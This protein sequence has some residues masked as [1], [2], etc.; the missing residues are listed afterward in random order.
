MTGFGDRLLPGHTLGHFRLLGR[1]GRGGM[2]EVWAAEDTRLRRR[3]ALKLLPAPDDG[4]DERLARFR[5]EAEALAALDHPNI[6][7]IFSIEE[8]EHVTFLAMQLVDGT[9]LHERVPPSGLPLPE[10]LELACPIADAIA[11][12]HQRGIAHRDLKPMCVV[13]KPKPTGPGSYRSRQERQKAPRKGRS[14]ALAVG[15]SARPRPLF[16][17]L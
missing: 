7:T 10:L 2:G 5:R 3:V 12:A 14:W 17:R 9:T 16:C 11:A 4:H 8:A 1:L 15:A 6:V 13:P